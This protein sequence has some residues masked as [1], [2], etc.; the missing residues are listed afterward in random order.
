MVISFF[1]NA[2]DDS[3]TFEPTASESSL[4][5][6]GLDFTTMTATVYHR[7]P[8]PDG[9]HSEAKGNVEYLSNGGILC[10][11]GENAYMT[12]YSR[13][14][15]EIVYEAAFASRRFANYRAYK[16]DFVG[17]PKSK[18]VVKSFASANSRGKLATSI[19]VSWNGATEVASW[20]FYSHVS[21]KGAKSIVPIGSTHKTGFETTYFAPGHHPIVFAEALDVD[22]RS[23]A[24]STLHVTEVPSGF[25]DPDRP[26]LSDVPKAELSKYLRGCGRP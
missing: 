7:H 10:G 18:P 17:Q 8:R 11:W 13:P 26:L 23:L 15:G 12:E 6:V 2:M 14:G 24:N 22:G 9:G 4:M 21:G 20:K 19:F 3:G 1:D 16:M 5:I 25:H